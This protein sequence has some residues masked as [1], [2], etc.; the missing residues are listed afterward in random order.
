M[1]TFLR[2]Q[3]MRIMQGCKGRA[4]AMPRKVLLA[5]LRLNHPTLTDRDC[6]EL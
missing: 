1:N 3:I 5:E 2:D 6:R 4:S